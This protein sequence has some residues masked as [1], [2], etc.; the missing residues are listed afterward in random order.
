MS[1]VSVFGERFGS[2]LVCGLSSTTIQDKIDAGQFPED[3][4]T[5]GDCIDDETFRALLNSKKYISHEIPVVVGKTLRPID[6]AVLFRF[7]MK[8][9]LASSVSLY[10]VVSIRQTCGKCGWEKNIMYGLS[11]PACDES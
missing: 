8:T 11:C 3:A 9:G 4:K 10:Y 2:A 7:T 1:L 5:V 6:G